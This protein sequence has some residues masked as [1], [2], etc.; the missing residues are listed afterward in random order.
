MPTIGLNGW[1]TIQIS[2][3]AIPNATVAD[4]TLCFLTC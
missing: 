2:E 4:L 3:K 1:M